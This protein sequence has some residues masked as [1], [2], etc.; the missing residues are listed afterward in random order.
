MKQISYILIASFF[1]TSCASILNSPYKYVT[2]HTTEPST[3][4]FEDNTINTTDNKAHLL[5]KRQSDPVRIIA[6]TDSLEKTIDIASKNSVAFW[7]NLSGGVLGLIGM[8]VDMNNPKRYTYPGK[9]FINSSDWK[10]TY[11]LFGKPN[12]KGEIYLHLSVPLVNPFRMAL[13]SEGVKSNVGIF[14]ATIGFDYYHSKDQF[15][16][17]GFS[18]VSGGS[19]PVDSVRQSTS[20]RPG[21]ESMNTQYLSISNNH[22]FGRFSIGY[23]ISYAENTWMYRR[24]GLFLI[25]PFMAEQITERHNAFG[26]IF[27]V[28]V[29]LGEHF[30]LGVVYRPT[31]FRPKM[32]N[33]FVYEHLI[34]LDF[35]WKI[36][37]NR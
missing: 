27:P 2:I 24:W 30:N 22:K 28:Y 21:R 16:H 17:F 5:V 29:Q 11:S 3:I 8:A 4:I 36:R 31:F 32:P 26:L 19:N 20:K 14:G 1:L 12:N 13:Q 37:I 34:S 9:I 10:N 15:I 23:G 7:A 25:I 18:A 33:R 6:T 35:A